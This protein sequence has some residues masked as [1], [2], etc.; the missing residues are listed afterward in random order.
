MKY[1]DGC[2]IRQQIHRWFISLIIYRGFKI[3]NHPGCR[4]SHPQYEKYDP[5]PARGGMLYVPLLIVTHVADPRLAA[6]LA[7]PLIVGAAMAGAFFEP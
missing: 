5:I 6:V 7:Q 4:I 1:C 2:E 3:V